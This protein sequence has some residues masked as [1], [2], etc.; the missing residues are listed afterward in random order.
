MFATVLPS[1]LPLLPLVLEGQ[2]RCPKDYVS[3]R[4]LCTGQIYDFARVTGLLRID[5]RL[6][7]PPWLFCLPRCRAF[8]QPI[9]SVEFKF[10]ARQVVAS[11]II[12]AAKLTFVRLRKAELESTLRNMLPQLATPCFAARQVGHKLAMQQWC[13]TSW[14]K[15]L[16]V[17][18]DLNSAFIWLMI[19]LL[20]IKCTGSLCFG[21]ARGFS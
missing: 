19:M 4:G 2:T 16:P 7:R 1:L 11:V 6:H 13:E 8:R 18:L 10:V 15:M 14:R 17:L 9:T 21:R 12:R 20:L 3:P 5:A